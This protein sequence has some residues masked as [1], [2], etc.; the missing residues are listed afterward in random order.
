[1]SCMPRTGKHIKSFA[2]CV[3]ECASL[4]LAKGKI[5]L[6]FCLSRVKKHKPLESEGRKSASLLLAWEENKR[7][8]LLFFTGKTKEHKSLPFK[9]A[10]CC[11][12]Q[13]QGR[14]YTASSMQ[15]AYGPETILLQVQS[16][17][18]RKAIHLQKRSWGSVEGGAWPQL[19]LLSEPAAAGALLCA[20]DCLKGGF[21]VSQQVLCFVVLVSGG[22][23]CGLSQGRLLS[24]PISASL[25]DPVRR[26]SMVGLYGKS[27][28]KYCKA[29]E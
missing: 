9:G 16:S 8:S 10:P 21:S 14:L 2:A 19:L 13:S 17:F 6:V 20:P 28:E 18:D 12:C 7:K 5:T 11:P 15:L 25:C 26:Q 23:S 1:M 29:A 27:V 24:E 22:T 3:E 4:L